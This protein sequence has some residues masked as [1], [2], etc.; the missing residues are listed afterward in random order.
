MDQLWQDV[1]QGARSLLKYP[2]SC[3]VAIVSLAAGIGATTATLTIRDVVFNKPPALYRQPQELSIVQVASR[4]RPIRP[5]GSLVPKSLFDLW[6]RGGVGGSLAAAAPEQVR[7]VRVDDRRES[8]R[9]RQVTPN[10]FA[11]LGVAPEAGR[12]FQDFTARDGPTPAVLSYRM[13]KFLFDGR[14]D[15]VGTRLW[16]GAE[17]CIVTGVLPERFWFSVMDSPIWTPLADNALP[18]DVET[19]VRRDRGITPQQLTDRLQR[20]LAAYASTLPAA[21]REMQLKVSAVEGTPMA[22]AM[23]VALPYALG[24]AVL[25]TLLIACANVAILAIAQW[26]AREHEIAIR[27]SLGASRARIVRALV[28][29]SVLLAAAGGLFGISATVAIQGLMLRRAGPALAFFDLSF[30][31]RIFVQAVA[32]TV[33]SGLAAGIGPALLETRRLQGNP[34]R[35][36]ATSDRVRQRWR[37]ALVAAEIAVTVVLLVVAGGM[38]D[39]YRRNY[40]ID[41]GY[42][43]HPLV[44]LRVESASGVQTRRIAEALTQVPGVERA[45][46]STAIPFLASGPMR[47]VSPGRGSDAVRAEQASTA[48]DFFATL[49]VAIRK[50]RAFTPQDSPRART[51]VVN[52]T[53][54]SRLFGAAD[55]IG[56][57]LW[58]DDSSYDIVGVVADYRNAPLQPPERDPK[59]FL[60]LPLEPAPKQVMFLVRAPGDAAAVQRAIRRE[61]PKAAAGLV[62][63]QAATAGQIIDVGGQEILV[64]TA[65]LAPLIAT[66]MLLTAA[67]IYGVLAFSIARRSKELAVR[68]AIG[69]THRNIVE[70]IASHSMRLVLIGS[71][72][73]VG[74]AFALSR[75]VRSYGA[76]GS[77]LDPGWASFVVPVVIIVA[78]GLVATWAPL[79]RARRIDPALLLRTT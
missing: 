25:L 42:P 5:T 31:P 78:V 73:G 69:A 15:V 8:V 75:I 77:F 60:P 13:W 44:L 61:I 55:P 20:G 71:A 16:I 32:I 63:S 64:G 23:M 10:F 37:H 12:T 67:G 72:C 1:R 41:V 49:G 27:A 43:T 7:E 50:G 28:V 11:T 3:V 66:G 74:G 6:S 53:L 9:I 18:A 56:R 51:A 17:P 26:T 22:K 52:E 58:I 76:E 34:M 38:L 33:L 14:S 57:E 39:T 30:E 36:M 70:L 46:A 2:V 68:I 45:A 29:E 47:R 40:R 79:R 4:D 24:T 54:A 21:E 19:I 65:P 48:P 59:V 62:V 35:A